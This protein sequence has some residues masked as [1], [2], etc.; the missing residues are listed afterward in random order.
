MLVAALLAYL[1]YYS[2]CEQVFGTTPNAAENAYNWVMT[3]VLPQQAGLTVSNVIYRYTTVKEID[4]EMVVHVQNENPVDGGYIFRSTDDWTGIPGNTINKVIPVGQIPIDYW[5]DGS[6]EIEGEGRVEEPF[7]AYTYQYDTCF[8][9]QADPNCPGYKTPIP[10]IPPVPDVADP[11]E[12]EYVQDEIDREM[13]MRDEEEE[14]QERRQVVKEEEDEEEVDL[15][16]ILGVVGRS[17]Q[18]AQDTARHNEQMALNAF[19]QQYYQS[20]P[21]TK[22]EETIQLKD[23]Q[24]PTNRRGR[25][26]Q[27]AQDLL[28]DKL[29]KSQYN[30]GEQ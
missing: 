26:L 1:P 15:E 4:D 6:I 19:T 28:H 11:L 18:N 2:Y 27:F 14:E 13:T 3:N 21:D 16:T 10:D 20:L 17:L 5:G 30:K 23:S 8:D 12:D 22:Y 9:P 25:R 24:L 7:V 29:V